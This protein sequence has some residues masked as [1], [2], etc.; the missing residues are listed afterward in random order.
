MTESIDSGRIEYGGPEICK[1]CASARDTMAG[2]CL[3]PTVGNHDP[4]RGENRSQGDHD[5]GHEMKSGRNTVPPEYQ[6]S[7][8]ARF[9][10]ER[11]DSLS[12]QCSAEYIPH[13]SRIS[14]PIRAELELHHNSRRHTHRKAGR[15]QGCPE[16]RGAFIDGFAPQE[17][18]SLEKHEDNP[19]PDGQRRKQIVKHN[20][21]RELQTGEK[22]DIEHLRSLTRPGSNSGGGLWSC[23]KNAFR[24]VGAVDDR[25]YFVESRKNA[26]SQTAPTVC[27]RQ[28]A[29]LFLSGPTRAAI[30]W[31]DAHSSTFGPK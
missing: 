26:R 30:E 10:K 24:V 16:S 29:N 1:L 15:V 19:H 4:D 7:K 23:K 22:D 18:H 6:D 3:L 2:W 21:Q 20:C 5:R 27:V 17:I 14:R 8:E 11:K 13:E 31:E 28:I 12:G 9:Q 25:P